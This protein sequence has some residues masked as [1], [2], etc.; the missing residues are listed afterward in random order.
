MTR[1]SSRLPLVCPRGIDKAKVR[2]MEVT[3]RI[4]EVQD[5]LTEVQAQRD[6]TV[7]ARDAD[8]T[9]RDRVTS[10]RNATIAELRT[11]L[12]LALEAS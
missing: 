6:N 1:L 8:I 3:N 7:A 10:D 9:Q 11:L 2:E 12:D 4:T 5:E